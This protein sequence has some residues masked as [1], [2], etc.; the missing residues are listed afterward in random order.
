MVIEMVGSLIQVKAPFAALK[1]G[2]AITRSANQTDQLSR[3]TGAGLSVGAVTD[4]EPDLPGPGYAAA[5]FAATGLA[6]LEWLAEP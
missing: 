5:A 3:T 6:D 1:A 4:C 2:M